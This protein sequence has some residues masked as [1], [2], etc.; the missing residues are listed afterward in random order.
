MCD[1]AGSTPTPGKKATIQFPFNAMIVSYAIF[2]HSLNGS[3]ENILSGNKQKQQ[4]K[5]KLKRNPKSLGSRVSFN[6]EAIRTLTV[7]SLATRRWRGKK[8]RNLPKRKRGSGPIASDTR[9]SY[10]V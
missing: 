6:P 9:N 8:F 1:D 2:S 7:R 10:S 4:R 3:S 5:K